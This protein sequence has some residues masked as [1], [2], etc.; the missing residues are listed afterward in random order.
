MTDEDAIQ[1]ALAYYEGKWPPEL[2]TGVMFFKGT[3]I[4]KQEFDAA[5]AK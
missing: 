5:R 2:W 4:T 3:R 1:E